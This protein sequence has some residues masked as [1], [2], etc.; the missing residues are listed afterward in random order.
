MAVDTV[1]SDGP[2]TTLIN[3]SSRYRKKGKDGR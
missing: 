2:L 3:D 1:S